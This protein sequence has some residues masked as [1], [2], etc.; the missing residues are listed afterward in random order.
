M[1]WGA[2]AV[3]GLLAICG[4]LI[5]ATGADA[6]KIK[7]TELED[8]F[9]SGA[10]GKCSLREAVQAANLDDSFGGCIREG[11]GTTDKILLRGGKVYD[12]TR[13]G[14]P[15]NENASGDLD[16]AGKTTIIVKGKGRAT[17]DANDL[18]RGI[19]VLPGAGLTASRLAITDGRVGGSEVGTGGG[20]ISNRGRL[21]LR[22]SVLFDNEAQRG[23]SGCG[24]GG[25]IENRRRMELHRVTLVHNLA[26]F[27]GG[28]LFAGNARPSIV[29]KSSIEGNTAFSGGGV[30]VFG[31]GELR[32]IQSAIL[33]NDARG[34]PT[35]DNNGGG[36]YVATNDGV[37]VRLT[38]STV[39]G[40]RAAEGGGGIFR[41]SGPLR[42]NAVTV[43]ANTA[44]LEDPA[45]VGH[46]GG[47]NGGVFGELAPDFG[48][49]RSIVA[50]N[51][52]LAATESSPDCFQVGG[53]FN[54]NN[55]LGVGTAC[56][57]GPRDLTAVDPKLKPLADN[58]GPTRTHAL[59][60]KSK[61]IGR[62]GSGAPKRDQRGVRRDARPDIGAFERR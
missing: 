37:V 50:A 8:D 35:S 47:I 52:D 44:E 38:N 42:L 55:L 20:G 16:L 22:R 54:R 21:D 40:N 33:A 31:S 48:V 51:L 59:K 11:S 13:G 4:A 9:F 15:E 43:T 25:G 34:S 7:V 46:G 62:A 26:T 24:C 57:E 30:Y 2:T 19:E 17:I 28:G 45:R 49:A 41:F 6:A 36:I 32:I 61:A 10:G 1:R 3:V 14:A 56:P 5:L 39:S 18:D 23:G 12:R 53:G 60:R 58:G 27:D 29:T